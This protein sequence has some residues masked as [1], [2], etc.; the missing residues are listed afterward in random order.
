MGRRDL[1][2]KEKARELINRLEIVNQYA[3]DEA[4]ILFHEEG[5]PCRHDDLS[6]KVNEFLKKGKF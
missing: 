1:F 5:E 2:A 3:C 6:F 4:C